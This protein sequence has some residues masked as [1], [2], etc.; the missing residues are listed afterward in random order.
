MNLV[1]LFTEHSFSKY[2]KTP[3]IFQLLFIKHCNSNTEIEFNKSS[4]S[5]TEIEFKVLELI[6]LDFFFSIFISKNNNNYYFL[7]F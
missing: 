5:N 6:L 7:K 4:N 1:R 3:K 2:M